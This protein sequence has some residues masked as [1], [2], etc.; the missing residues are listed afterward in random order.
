MTPRG[1]S[2]SRLKVA[3]LAA[4]SRLRMPRMLRSSK[5][6][7][8]PIG[9]P[10]WGV[11]PCLCTAQLAVASGSQ[12]CLLSKAFHQLVLRRSLYAG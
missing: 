12:T 2:A 7:T 1:P 4:S 11:S 9:P 8:T 5:E 10:L 3:L 6:H